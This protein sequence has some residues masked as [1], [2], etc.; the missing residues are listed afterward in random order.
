MNQNIEKLLG[1]LS[2][3][4]IKVRESGDLAAMHQVK[5]EIDR[6]IKTDYAKLEEAMQQGYIDALG[7]R[8]EAEINGWLV[9]YKPLERFALDSDKL[10]SLYNGDEE[11]MKN[12]L[13]SHSFTKPSLKFKNLKK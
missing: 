3:E 8:D 1:M 13:Y 10:K 2:M 9:T 5:L 12:E 11:R 6:I 7:D 4:L